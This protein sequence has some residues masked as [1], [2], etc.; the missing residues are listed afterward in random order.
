MTFWVFEIG[1]AIVIIIGT[2]VAIADIRDRR[3]LSHHDRCL[4][5]ISRLE[6]ELGIWQDSPWNPGTGSGSPTYQRAYP[7]GPYIIPRRSAGGTVAYDAA[8]SPAYNLDPS[9]RY[10]AIHAWQSVVTTR[11]TRND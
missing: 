9:M 2:T 8:V 1:C 6:Q 11:R 3:R 4:Q 5:Q 10:E 7:T